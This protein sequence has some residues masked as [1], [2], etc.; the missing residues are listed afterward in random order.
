MIELLPTWP[1]RCWHC[2]SLFGDRDLDSSSRIFALTKLLTRLPL[3]SEQAG[4]LVSSKKFEANPTP[5][6]RFCCTLYSF[7][8]F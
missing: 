4:S 6:P 8:I 7:S 1:L 5:S 3:A 2:P